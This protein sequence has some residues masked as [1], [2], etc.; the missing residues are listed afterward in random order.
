MAV[1]VGGTGLG[2]TVTVG[3]GGGTVTVAVEGMSVGV[4]Q[5]ESPKRSASRVAWIIA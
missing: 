1:A 3:A 2:V 4:E 5:A